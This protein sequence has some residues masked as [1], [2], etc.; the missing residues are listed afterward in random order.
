M[1]L[2]AVSLPAADVSAVQ[3]NAGK[4]AHC[5][6]TLALFLDNDG[7]PIEKKRRERVEVWEN[8]AHVWFSKREEVSG[9]RPIEFEVCV[10]VCVC[11]YT[12]LS[13]PRWNQRLGER[14]G[15]AGT[16]RLV[17]EKKKREKNEWAEHAHTVHPPVKQGDDLHVHT[18]RN[19]NCTTYSA[20]KLTS[21]IKRGSQEL[22]EMYA[23]CSYFSISSFCFLC[24][25][26][27]RRCFN[28]C[29]ILTVVD[30][31]H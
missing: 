2:T 31:S 18:S 6:Q 24:H 27:R 3:F 4:K 5:G 26:R 15:W 17:V 8:C 12:C 9:E 29:W 13:L 1:S 22:H 20:S 30:W 16:W 7:S 14:G 10:C 19:A 21:E 23:K 11:M 25:R 28:T